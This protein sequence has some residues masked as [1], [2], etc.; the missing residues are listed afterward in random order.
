METNTSTQV[1]GAPEATPPS[2]GSARNTFLTV[3]CI[4]SFIGSGWGI[5]SSIKS[6]AT[7]DTVAAI[8]GSA[9]KTAQ[10]QMDQQNTPDVAKKIMSSV[11]EGLNPDNIRKKAIMDFISNI[12]TLLGA[13]MM[14]NLKKSGFYLYIA[15]IVVLI[16]AP[17]VMGKLIGILAGAFTGI[18]GV[19]FIIMYGVN[20]KQMTK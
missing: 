13:I 9:M 10:D 18:V 8:A 17:L 6:Y 1:P 11:S 19:A 2:S 14:W 12:L 7:A 3:I 15:G 20:L 4:L 5:I 16:A